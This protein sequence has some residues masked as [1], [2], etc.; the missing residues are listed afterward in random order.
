[1]LWLLIRGG[2][3]YAVM[4]SM[5]ELIDLFRYDG[6]TKE[7]GY[8][9]YVRS[10]GF[11]AF[12]LFRI[13]LIV[14]LF[15]RDLKLLVRYLGAPMSIGRSIR[16][17]CFY[18]LMAFLITLCFYFWVVYLRLDW[19][20]EPDL[21]ADAYIYKYLIDPI[22]E[23]GVFGPVQFSMSAVLVGLAPMAEELLFRGVIFLIL[24]AIF[25]RFPAL[26]LSSVS[27]AFWHQVLPDQYNWYAIFQHAVL[28][29]ALGGI[30]LRTH[31]LRW[32][33]IFHSLWNS[34]VTGMQIIW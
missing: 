16:R 1:M 10:I 30:L 5:R 22:R 3:Y 34:W 29:F 18:T 28:G 25:G 23:S 33:I 15:G 19:L 6:P 27:F 8:Y 7:W 32:S 13:L 17:V 4:W 26:V 24:L 20:M 31:R 21:P 11:I 14:L 12:Y 2:I 9:I